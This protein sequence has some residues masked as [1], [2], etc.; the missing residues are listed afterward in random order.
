MGESPT[1]FFIRRKE[2][3]M[4]KRDIELIQ[5]F[6]A[7]DKELSMLYKEH[8]EYEKELEKLE[9]KSYLT[10]Q[11]QMERTEIKKKK[12]VGRDKIEMLLGKYRQEN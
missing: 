4:E 9:N 6:V 5:K 10:V 8:L 11:E 2:R 1:A 12:L 3:K 7:K